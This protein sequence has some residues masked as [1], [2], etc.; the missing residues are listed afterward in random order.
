MTFIKEI[1]ILLVIFIDFVYDHLVKYYSKLKNIVNIFRHLYLIYRFYFII[2]KKRIG[3]N[4]LFTIII[5][6]KCDCNNNLKYLNKIIHPTWQC[7]V[8][9]NH[10]I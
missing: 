5:H 1:E 4:K 7:E 10:N 9:S 2:R 8:L 6:K 3:N